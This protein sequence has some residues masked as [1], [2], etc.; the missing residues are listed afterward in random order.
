VVSP[1]IKIE[2]I[3]GSCPVQAEGTIDG[4][5]FYFRARGGA[6]RLNIGGDVVCD[7]EWSHHEPYGDSPFAAGWMSEDDARFFIRKAAE[8][9]LLTPKE[10]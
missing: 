6:W 2:M 3:G 1:A 9:Y 5:E 7:P 8:L 4:R 10:T